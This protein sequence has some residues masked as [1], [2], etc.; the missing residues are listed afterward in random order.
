MN[1]CMRVMVVPF[2]VAFAAGCSGEESQI[3]L[4]APGNPPNTSAGKV[5]HLELVFPRL[6]LID[7][8]DA[9]LKAYELEELSGV[10]AVL[11][12]SIGIE[13]D[14]KGFKALMENETVVP[15]T[16][17]QVISTAQENQEVIKVHFQRKKGLP[18]AKPESIGT[19]EVSGIPMAPAGQP[20][21]ELRCTMN[22]FGDFKVSATDKSNGSELLVRLIEQ[23]I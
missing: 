5:G 8:S 3:I 18:D 13:I 22:Q 17:L 6:H 7:N 20:R 16:V 1:V 11:C 14:G 21:I 23:G 10:L 4:T 15:Y 9:T 19:V 2:L 12:E